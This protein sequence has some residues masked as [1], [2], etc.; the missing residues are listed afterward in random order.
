MIQLFQI[1]KEWNNHDAN[2]NPT[3]AFSRQAEPHGGAMQTLL[4]ALPPAFAEAPPPLVI[5]YHVE[6]GPQGQQDQIVM[7]E[8]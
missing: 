8:C 3:H 7:I 1:R 2:P 5:S 6:P 4:L